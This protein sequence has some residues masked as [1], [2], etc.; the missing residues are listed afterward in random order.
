[1]KKRLLSLFVLITMLVYSLPLYA[2]AEYTTHKEYFPFNDIP[3]KSWYT[4][5]VEF[6]YINGFMKG[7]G[8]ACFDPQGITTREQMIMIMANMMGED[9]SGYT[10]CSFTDVAPDKWYSNAVAWAEQKGYAN[11][12]GNGRFGLGNRITREEA[13]TFFYNYLKDSVITVSEDVLSAYED[14]ENVSDWAIESMKWAVSSAVV[15]GNDDKLD[16]KGHLTRA[17][18]AQMIYN[19]VF[20]AMYTDHEH[21]FNEGSCTEPPVCIVRGCTLMLSPARGHSFDISENCESYVSCKECG[22]LVYTPLGHE[23]TAATCSSPMV[24]VKC[25]K[26]EGSALGHTVEEGFCGRCGEGIFADDY[27]KL[28][29]C[30]KYKGDDK[31]NAKQLYT[32]VNYKNGDFADQFVGYDYSSGSC[33]FRFLYR[34]KQSG[35]LIEINMKFNGISDNYS[36]SIDYFKT[37]EKL[38]GGKGSIKASSFDENTKLAFESVSGDEY[39]VKSLKELCTPAMTLMLDAAD[40]ILSRDCCMS[41]IDIGFI[42]F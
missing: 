34:F 8:A 2:S 5:S 17:Q 26:T 37:D 28:T 15:K 12:V 7:T 21:Q 13:V 23:Y 18:A 16:P 22:V 3:G 38:C 19:I 4:S 41:V 1:M 20:N 25:N 42:N 11:G 32:R 27:H 9:T 35:D 29:Y 24:C 10:E 33:Y 6:C 30:I 40:H 39:Y 36:Y 14:A 31:P